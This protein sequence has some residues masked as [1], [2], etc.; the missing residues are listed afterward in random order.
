MVILNFFYVNYVKIQV[1][2][3]TVVGLIYTLIILAALSIAQPIS[4]FFYKRKFIELY[5]NLFF[6]INNIK[7]V[8]AC[9][10]QP[11]Y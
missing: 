5:K 9:A 4:V 10:L 8:Y 1:I 3:W 6:Y 11:S 7:G 2:A